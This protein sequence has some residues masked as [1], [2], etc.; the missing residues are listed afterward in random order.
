MAVVMEKTEDLVAKATWKK[1]QPVPFQAVADV[2]HR[3]EQ[4]TKR[5]GPPCAALPSRAGFP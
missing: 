4:T 2:F 1:G 5:C 3:V